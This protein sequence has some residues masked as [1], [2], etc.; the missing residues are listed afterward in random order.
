M[1]KSVWQLKLELTPHLG[2]FF[3]RGRKGQE[4][5][6]SRRTIGGEETGGII[7][8]NSYW[9]CHCHQAEVTYTGSNR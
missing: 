7:S 2:W 6:G 9:I 5:E 8:T 4:R 1:Q 3:F